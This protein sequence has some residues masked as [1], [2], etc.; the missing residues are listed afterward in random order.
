MGNSHPCSPHLALWIFLQACGRNNS[1]FDRY[2]C[3]YYYSERPLIFTSLVLARET[4]L[5][6]PREN[7]REPSDIKVTAALS[8]HEN[9][10]ILVDGVSLKETN[11]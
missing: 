11:Q 10:H 6:F 2:S 7:V 4:Q 8:Y 5:A 3:Y 1:Y 9:N